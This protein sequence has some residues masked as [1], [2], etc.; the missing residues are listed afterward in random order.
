M[1]ILLF[2]M[3]IRGNV[4]AF[5]HV[6]AENSDLYASIS[7]LFDNVV[8]DD[9]VHSTDFFSSDDNSD[10]VADK[11]LIHADLNRLFALERTLFW[12]HLYGDLCVP[13]FFSSDT[14]PPTI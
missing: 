11:Y 7:Y 12:G 13:C 14:S 8:I 10:D 6:N 5:C 1:T 4:F 9:N 2:S 3:A